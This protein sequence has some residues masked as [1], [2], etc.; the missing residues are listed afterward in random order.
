M[1]LHHLTISP[2]VH[3]SSNFSNSFQHLLLS[4]VHSCLPN[5]CKAVSC[6]KVSFDINKVIL[7]NIVSPL[8]MCCKNLIIHL[9]MQRVLKG[10]STYLCISFLHTCNAYNN[11]LIRHSKRLTIHK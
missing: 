3:E 1:L 4:D 9:K 10:V 6:V 2:S 5:K 11:L 7:S 8:L